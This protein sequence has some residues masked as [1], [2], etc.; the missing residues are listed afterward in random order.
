MES[1]ICEA[2][3]KSTFIIQRLAGSRYPHSTDPSWVACR[4]VQDERAARYR[5]LVARLRSWL[6]GRKLMSCKC[7]TRN[8]P[9]CS[10]TRLH[11]II[12]SLVVAVSAFFV[13]GSYR[14]Q[15]SRSLSKQL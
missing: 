11:E 10:I 4:R 8:H 7:I 15:S 6:V 9:P 12:R 13:T 2:G 1:I 14:S 5:E 3:V